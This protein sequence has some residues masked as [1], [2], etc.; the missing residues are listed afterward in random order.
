[1]AETPRNWAGN[2]AYAT[3]DIRMPRHRAELQDLVKH[4]GKLRALG[5]RH[6]FNRIADSD[7]A[8]VSLKGFERLYRLDPA[9]RTVTVDGGAT[10]GDLCPRLDADGFALANLAS[11]PHISIVGAV[12]TATH[13]SGNLNRNL[14]AAVAALELVTAGG[15]IVTLRR[16][17]A[18]FAGAVVGLGALGIVTA[19]TLDVVPRFEVRQNVYVDLPFAAY[20]DNF[21]AI[22]GS[23]YSVSAF[24][25]WRGDSIA[26]VWLKSLADAPPRPGELFGA[27]P[28]DRPYHPIETLDPAPATEQLGVPGPWYLRLP[29]F[30][31]EFSPSAGAELQSEYFV[32][33]RDGPAALRALHAVQ[34]R[35]AAPLMVSELRTVAADELWLSSAQG[36]DCLAFHFTWQRDWPSVQQVLPV[37][38]QALAPFAVRPH[39]GK[40]FTM[41]KADIAA[42]WP[43]LEAFRELA[44]KYDPEGK[45]RNAFL[46]ETIF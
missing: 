35:F 46:T 42:R 45:F 16:G 26:H 2:I 14:A 12:A 4:A 8:I 11:L 29:H 20:V 21:D 3:T 24:T 37:I 5:S 7:H 13:G 40:L 15:D 43:R 23:A 36:Q 22:T 17:D 44:R 34:E 19:I 33:R 28:A 25:H 32:P 18:D 30:R 39:W 38:E 31:I 41:H 1:M 27:R 9:A 6:S 10:Y